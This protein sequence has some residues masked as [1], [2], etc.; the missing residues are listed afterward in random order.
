MIQMAMRER[1]MSNK[2]SNKLQGSHDLMLGS[3]SLCLQLI[4][5]YLLVHRE[6]LCVH[7]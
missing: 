2:L 6:G 3:H 5:F 1:T 7:I 4:C